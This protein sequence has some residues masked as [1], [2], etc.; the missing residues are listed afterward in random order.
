[1]TSRFVVTDDGDGYG[2]R[3]AETKSVQPRSES[4]DSIR[5]VFWIRMQAAL[6]R[7]TVRA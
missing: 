7:G 5:P 3:I 1:M 6:Y 4:P 2:R